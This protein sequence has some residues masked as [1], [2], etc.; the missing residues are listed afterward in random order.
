M[1]PT[2]HLPLHAAVGLAHALVDDVARRARVRALFIKGPIADA[3][4]IRRPHPSSDADV[5]VDPREADRLL[6]LLAERGWSVRPGSA[7]HRAFVTHSV[8]LLHPS[9]PCDID[10]HTSW[11]GFFTDPQHAFEVLWRTRCEIEVAGVPVRASGVD[12]AVVVSALHSL[13]SPH[14]RRSEEELDELVA[15][16]AAQHREGA[17]AALAAELGCLE[18][19]APFLARIGASV[20]LPAR[21]SQQ[22]ALWRLRTRRPSRTADWLL[23]VAEAPTLAERLVL[24]RR[25]LLPTRRDLVVD[26]PLAPRTAVARL[27]LRG[28]RFAAAAGALPVAVRDLVAVRRARTEVR[29]APDPRERTA[30]PRRSDAP[31]APAPGGPA[32]SSVGGVDGASAETT[33]HAVSA[34]SRRPR[35]RAGVA[36]MATADGLYLLPLG[37]G[38]PA[39]P[40]LLQGAAR[41]LWE[42]FS[43]QGCCTRAE[44]AAVVRDADDLEAL[45]AA[46]AQADLDRLLDELVEL[47]LLTG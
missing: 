9:W 8:T 5:L 3:H 18:P 41:L 42:L 47:G 38:G 33:G 36:T 24:L 17:V 35:T 31:P 10:V 2:A 29:G 30:E 34:S 15:A 28:R 25:A 44:A 37:A 26:H 20:A 46:E 4:R 39:R 43:E 14:Q 11:P 19:I 12:A 21:P 23:A 45:V 1:R 7:A 6:A 22:Y 16:V 40:Y 27:G 32:A 13:R